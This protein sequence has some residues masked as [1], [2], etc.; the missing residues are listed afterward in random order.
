MLTIKKPKKCLCMNE[1]MQRHFFLQA[2]YVTGV[3]K[4]GLRSLLYKLI[5]QHLYPNLTGN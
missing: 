2:A 4:A 5:I 3:I 1:S